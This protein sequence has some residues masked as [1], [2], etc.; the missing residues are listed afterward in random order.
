MESTSVAWTFAGQERLL[1]G[2]LPVW[3]T[4]TAIDKLQLPKYITHKAEYS[5]KEYIHIQILLLYTYGTVCTLILYFYMYVI[6]FTWTNPLLKYG[7]IV[8]HFL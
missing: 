3:V 8:C 4:W 5:F 1:H 2:L 7:H 6:F